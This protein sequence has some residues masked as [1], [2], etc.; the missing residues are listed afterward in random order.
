MHRNALFL[1]K[2]RKNHLGLEAPPQTPLPPATRTPASGGFAAASG[3]DHWPPAASS[4]G[5]IYLP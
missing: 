3:V 2:N 4:T 1:L 5:P